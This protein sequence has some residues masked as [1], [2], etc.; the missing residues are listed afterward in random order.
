MDPLGHAAIAKIVN[1][2]PTKP[3]AHPWQVGVRVKGGKSDSVHWCGATIVNEHHIL[4][5]AHCLEDFPKGL[6]VLRVGDYNSQV[7]LIHLIKM[8]EMKLSI[9]FN[10]ILIRRKRNIPSNRCTFTNCLMRRLT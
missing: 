1:G 4:T 8:K 3:G 5:A 6:Y 10:R 7:L 2:E 9:V